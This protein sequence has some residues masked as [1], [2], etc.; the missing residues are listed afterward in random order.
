MLQAVEIESGWSPTPIDLSEDPVDV[1]RRDDPVDD[2]GTRL[3]AP[4][5][6]DSRPPLAPASSDGVER[7]STRSA[8]SGHHGLISSVG[9][10]PLGLSGRAAPRPVQ[11]AASV[12]QPVAHRAVPVAPVAAVQPVVQRVA[13]PQAA[14]PVSQPV[15]SGSML[16]MAHA[17]SLPA[18][19]P[20]PMPVNTAPW[21]GGN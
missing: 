21:N 1:R 14:A 2:D 11:P 6:I 18:P 8:G 17:G 7:T 9:A 4:V 5:V 12:V 16:G 20:R 10:T 19:L 3:K 15:Y 13:A